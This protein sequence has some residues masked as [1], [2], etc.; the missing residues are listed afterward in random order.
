VLDAHDPGVRDMALHQPGILAPLP[1]LGR[2]LTFACHPQGSYRAALAALARS[3]DGEGMVVGIGHSLALALGRQIPGLGDFP[4]HAQAGIEVPSTP[5]ALW[6]WLRG[7]ERGELLQRSRQ[8]CDRFAGAFLL[9]QAID[10]FIHA[11]GR[12]LTGFRDGTENPKGAAAVRAA[13]VADAGAGQDGGSYVAVQQWQHDFTAFE[14]MSAR[15]QEL[16]IGRRLV[17]DVE[18]SRVPASAHVKRT[19]QESFSPEAFVL[20][21]SMP[22][23]EGLAGGLVFVAFGSSTAA[24]AAQLRRMVGAEDGIQDALFTFT[25]PRT[26]AYF[27]C[28]PMKGGLLDLSLLTRQRRA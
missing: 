18:I 6:C 12:D 13:F 21:R 14:A 26:G 23:V 22:W 19:A 25:R 3:T 7:S 24:F 20:R 27:W 16:A 9:T 10:A 17:D 8:L 15:Q 28:P 11:D 1:P 4:S 5:S 2:Y